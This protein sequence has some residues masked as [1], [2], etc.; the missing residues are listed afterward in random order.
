MDLKIINS[1][2]FHPRKNHGKLTSKDKL[3]PVQNNI[4]VG[5]KFHL[6]NPAF[7]TI[8]FFHGNGEIASEYDDIAQLYNHLNLNFIIADF[9][10]YGFSNGEPNTL[11]I[12][13]DSHIIL[14]YVK[15]YLNNNKFI[16]PL[17]LMGRSLGSVSVIELS[18]RYPNDF[19][20]IIIE[21][22]YFLK[23]KK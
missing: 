17:F 9:R 4:S 23:L 15:L 6:I 7:P 21:T 8:L 19:Y 22:L 11:N 13:K 12:Q 18:K 16:K 1:F 20:G 5:I 2:L 3:I 14:D 10:G